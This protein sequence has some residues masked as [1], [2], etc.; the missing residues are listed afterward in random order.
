[1]SIRLYIGGQW[2][3]GKGKELCSL[4]RESLQRGMFDLFTSDITRIPSHIFYVSKL[5]GKTEIEL[6]RSELK[7]TQEDITDGDLGSLLTYVAGVYSNMGNYKCFGD[8][9]IV[10]AITKEKFK[11]KIWSTLLYKEEQEYVEKFWQ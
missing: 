7:Q 1:M 5:Y 9:K 8:T 10:P 11:S 2:T 3:R 4:S 6:L